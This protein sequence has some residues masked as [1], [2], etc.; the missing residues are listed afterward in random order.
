MRNMI[1]HATVAGALL[2]P[3]ASLAAAHATDQGPDPISAAFG[4]GLAIIGDAMHAVPIVGPISTSILEPLFRA[5]DSLPVI[6]GVAAA[7][8]EDFDKD[9]GGHPI[10]PL[11]TPPTA[12]TPAPAG[13]AP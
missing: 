1:I 11:F 12:P 4:A 3:G 6:G 13:S 2:L 8:Y 5:A 9:Q 7:A 10:S